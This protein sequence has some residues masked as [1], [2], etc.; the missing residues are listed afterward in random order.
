MPSRFIVEQAELLHR[1]RDT[2]MVLENIRNRYATSSF[3]S[4]MSRVKAEWYRFNE[5]HEDFATTMALGY[6]R[7]KKQEQEVPK[8]ALRELKAYT[9]D[10]LATQMKKRRSINSPGGLTGDEEA[11]FLISSTPVLPGYMSGYRLSPEDKI[12]SSEISR[13]SL[14]ERSM[15]CVVVEDADALLERCRRVIKDLEEDPFFVAACLSVACGRRSIEILATGSFQPVEGRDHACLFS[16]AA[17]K[18]SLR[19]R[20]CE[21]PLLV[22]S[23]YVIAALRHVRS[24]VPCEG[25]TNSQINSR[26]SHKLGDA[27]KILMNNLGVRFHD[28][29]CIYGVVS[30]RAFEHDGSINI[31]LKKALLHETLDTSVFYSRCRVD[32]C[33]SRLGRWD[34]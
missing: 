18:K 33:E 20:P 1:T 27:A 23:K 26:F 11:D 8:R 7:L 24:S 31:W 16:G 17:K 29:R 25:L 30:F 3:C 32:K 10:D 6:E 22:K 21:I 34:L 19:S 15:A 5:R 28:L 13:K 9:R 2:E 4:Q 14:E 12:V